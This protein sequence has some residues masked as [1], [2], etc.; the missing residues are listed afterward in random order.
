MMFNYDE[1]LIAKMREMKKN[2][3]SITAIIEFLVESLE[4]KEENARLTAIM[5]FREAFSLRLKDAMQIGSWEFFEGGNWD[6][7][8]MEREIAPLLKI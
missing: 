1:E 3:H 7:E 6:A 5:Y 2:R 4:L 8:M